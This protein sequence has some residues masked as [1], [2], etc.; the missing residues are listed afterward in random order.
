M[1]TSIPQT[2]DIGHSG[3]TLNGFKIPGTKVP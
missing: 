1:L 3:I 2:I